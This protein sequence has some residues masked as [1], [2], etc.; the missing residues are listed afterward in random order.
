MNAPHETDCPADGFQ[1]SAHPT[2]HG[3]ID[4]IFEAQTHR[5]A[6]VGVLDGVRAQLANIEAV[7]KT[8]VAEDP[9]CTNE[10]RRKAT[11]ERLL[12]DH[13]KHQK[14]KH[15]EAELVRELSGL[16][17]RLEALRSRLS[18]GK[19]LLAHETARINARL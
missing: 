4:G 15:E 1:A 13:P 10:A 3:L 5:H 6:R 17:A 11:T 12:A 14:L 2:L 16:D 19:V 8:D 7:V 18:V 9:A